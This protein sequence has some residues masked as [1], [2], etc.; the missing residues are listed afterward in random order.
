MLKVRLLLMFS[1]N[2]MLLLLLLFLRLNDALTLEKI[3]VIRIGLRC[4]T[5]SRSHSLEI[6]LGRVDVIS[7]L[8]LV[9]R[10]LPSG[11]QDLHKLTQLIIADPSIAINCRIS[12]N[13]STTGIAAFYTGISIALAAASRG[14]PDKRCAAAT[15]ARLDLH[16]VTAG[17]TLTVSAL[18]SALV[19]P[20]LEVAGARGDGRPEMSGETEG[21]GADSPLPSHGSTALLRVAASRGISGVAA[22]Q[23]VRHDARSA[24]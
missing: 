17:L 7:T 24:A 18:Q 16:L 5:L 21:A 23:S 14:G 11:S 22:I 4:S 8:T 19:Q 2:I 3:L 10:Q 6:A 15:D 12:N 9:R 20:H 1:I 13:T